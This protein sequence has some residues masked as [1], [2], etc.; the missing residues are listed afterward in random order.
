[1]SLYRITRCARQRANGQRVFVNYTVEKI[2][3][4]MSHHFGHVYLPKATIISHLGCLFQKGTW[5]RG[6]NVCELI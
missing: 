4:S 2:M 5:E 1:M 6:L 3:Q